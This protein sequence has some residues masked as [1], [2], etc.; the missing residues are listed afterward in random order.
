MSLGYPFVLRL[1]V[2]WRWGDL[3]GRYQLPQNYRRSQFVDF[4]V[5][6]NY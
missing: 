1:D 2:G 6:I 4:W 3:Q 5:G